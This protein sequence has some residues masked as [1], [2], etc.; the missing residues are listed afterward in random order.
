MVLIIDVLK[1][2][3]LILKESICVYLWLCWV[4]IAVCWLSLIAASRSCSLIAAHLIEAASRCR[5][6]A[7]GVA[8]V[9]RVYGLSCFVACGIFPDQ[10]L[11]PCSLHR[12]VDSQTLDHQGSPQNYLF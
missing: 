1:I 11:N 4:S 8:S 6:W 5:V 3:F 9:V 12:Q 7:S 2:T 10:E